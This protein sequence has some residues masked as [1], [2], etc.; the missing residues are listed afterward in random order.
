MTLCSE[1]SA[2]PRFV[3][4]SSAIRCRFV[5]RLVS[6][7]VL[8]LVSR[9]RFSS[10][11]TPLPSIG[12]RCGQFPDVGSTIEVLRLPATHPRSLICFASRVHAILPVRVSQLSLALLEGRRLP[13]RPGSMFS[14]GPTCR[15][16]F[17]WT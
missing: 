8:S 10:H 6:L 7:R 13:S 15:H 3:L 2:T 17:A 16:A 14:R 4:A 11:D 5:D 12:S 9:Q 1:D